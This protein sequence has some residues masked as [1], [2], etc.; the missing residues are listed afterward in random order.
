MSLKFTRELQV[1]HKGNHD[2]CTIC[3]KPFKNNDRTHLG[4]KKNRDLVYSCNDCSDELDETVIRYN[5]SK[6]SYSTPEA[7]TIL[8][9]YIDF[10]KF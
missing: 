7:S 1:F 6:R 9:R 5:F 10:G 4:Y 2:N 8:W 3:D